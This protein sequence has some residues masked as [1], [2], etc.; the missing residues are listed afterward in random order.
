[1]ARFFKVLGD[2][3]YSYFNVEEVF[4][5]NPVENRIEVI[6]NDGNVLLVEENQKDNVIQEILGG[7]T[8]VSFVKH[9]ELYDV[10]FDP[11]DTNSKVA[12]RAETLVLCA[13]GEIRSVEHDDGY[14][15]FN[16]DCSNYYGLH[17]KR[18]LDHISNLRMGW[19]L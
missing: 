5:I 11:E 14:T 7:R 1:M 2:N 10:Y 12:E 8:V 17:T 6:F 13:D 18:S 4:S 15:M 16:E 9:M 19:L 3:G